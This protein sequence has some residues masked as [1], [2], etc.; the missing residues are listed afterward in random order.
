M[1]KILD[2]V[3]FNEDPNEKNVLDHL[4]NLLHPGT[5]FV[6][7][8]ANSGKYT[9]CANKSIERGSIYAIEPDSIKFGQLKENC[10]KWET[11]SDNKIHTLQ[12]AISQKEEQLKFYAANSPTI[13][14]IFQQNLSY[15]KDEIRDTVAW[16]ET[17]ID[18]FSLDT[19]FTAIN[20]DLIKI[21]VVGDELNILQGST[22]ILQ[23]GKTRFLIK[24]SHSAVLTD[25]NNQ[26]SIDNFMQ[27]FGYRATNFYGMHLFCNPK[28]YKKY[29][30]LIQASRK[31]YQQ[32]LPGYLRHWTNN[33]I[34]V[35]TE[36]LLR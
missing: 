9:F 16:E 10:L 19:L 31:L 30:Y 24:I 26:K 32:L 18:S 4:A 3:N 23:Q 35:L 15:V 29:N 21:D 1:K 14:R 11:L 6:D 33:S 22:K 20:P 2:S 13:G 7:I 8:G 28:K 36:K 34:Q 5:I 25:K 27:P 17:I 12:I